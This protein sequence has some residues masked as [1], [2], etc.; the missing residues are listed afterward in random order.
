MNEEQYELLGFITS[1]GTN[2]LSDFQMKKGKEVIDQKIAGG[3]V[4]DAVVFDLETAKYK[5]ITRA[6]WDEIA[7]KQSAQKPKD[8]E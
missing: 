2:N 4:G 1:K 7:A 3:E 6:R 5:T 8:K